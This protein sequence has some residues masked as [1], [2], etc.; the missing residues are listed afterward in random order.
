MSSVLIRQQRNAAALMPDRHN[1]L[2]MHVVRDEDGVHGLHQAC[3]DAASPLYHFDKLVA[4][5]CRR[6][7]LLALS[8]LTRHSDPAMSAFRE[9]NGL[10][11]LLRTAAD[12]SDARQ[13]RYLCT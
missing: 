13:Q 3:M 5:H 2:S 11:L 6:K 10:Q 7:A 1:G 8:C 12:A 9:Q 4:S